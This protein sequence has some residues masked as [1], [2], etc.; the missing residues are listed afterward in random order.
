MYNKHDNKLDVQRL[1]SESGVRK[2]RIS[3]ERSEGMKYEEF[4]NREMEGS[5]RC[6][7]AHSWMISL[8]KKIE[9]QN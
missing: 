9:T 5:R 6:S 2:V 1:R 8:E 4:S 3:K 7:S